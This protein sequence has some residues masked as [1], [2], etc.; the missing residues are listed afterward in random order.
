[1]QRH[2][3]RTP[4]EW[5][6]ALREQALDTAYQGLSEKGLVRKQGRRV[7]GVFGSV[8]YPVTGLSELV[9]LRGRLAVVLVQ[10]QEADERTA[11]LITV[12]HHAGLQAVTPQVTE[13]RLSGI[14]EGQ[15]SVAALGDAIRTTVAALTARSVGLPSV[16]EASGVASEVGRVASLRPKWGGVGGSCGS[17]VIVGSSCRA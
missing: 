15:G 17:D 5:L 6:L 9:V 13:E 14:A 10:G 16:V 3:E 11:A 7:L 8:T 12:L 2:P 4:R 1:M